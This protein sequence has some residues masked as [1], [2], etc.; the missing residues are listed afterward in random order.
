[1]QCAVL[2]HHEVIY[3]SHHV[4]FPNF[5][6]W[7][8][9]MW[10]KFWGKFSILYCCLNLLC[11][12]ILLCIW[13]GLKKNPFCIVWFWGWAEFLIFTHLSLMQLFLYKVFAHARP[14][15]FASWVTIV[16]SFAKWITYC[17]DLPLF[18]IIWDSFI[19][20]DWNLCPTPAMSSRRFPMIVPS[21]AVVNFVFHITSLHFL[22][23]NY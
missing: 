2:D 22:E 13:N 14:S 20:V 11:P 1:L 7:D 8:D 10:V 12:C 23:K 5:L 17:S 19:F 3:S 6:V 9:G 16:P 18:L 15:F 21:V 4:R